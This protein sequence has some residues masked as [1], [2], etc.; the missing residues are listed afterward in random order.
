VS[1]KK[2]LKIKAM[3]KRNLL[4]HALITTL[5]FACAKVETV[6]PATQITALLGKWG[7]QSIELNATD[8]NVKLT[9]DCAT[10]EIVK[11]VNFT[12]NLLAEEGTFTQFSGNVPINVN[13]PP[14]AKP[15]KYEGKLSGNELT[16][17]I[18]SSDGSTIIGTYTITKDQAGKIFRCL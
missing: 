9:F 3:C 7:G 18:K 2:T 17:T 12:N 4:T 16:L 11:K 8:T 13:N 1:C 6:A 10:G 14:Q 5:L 15:V